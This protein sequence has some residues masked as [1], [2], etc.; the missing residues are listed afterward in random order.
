M[1]MITNKEHAKAAPFIRKRITEGT[2]LL[3]PYDLIRRAMKLVYE[4]EYNDEVVSNVLY[5]E[6]FDRGWVNTNPGGE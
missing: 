4:G 6:L 5:D 1:I 2:G 3:T